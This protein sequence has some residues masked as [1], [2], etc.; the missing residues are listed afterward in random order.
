MSDVCEVLIPRRVFGQQR[1]KFLR[2]ESGRPTRAGDCQGSS[3]E[4]VS[5]KFL[6]VLFWSHYPPFLSDFFV[7]GFCP[8]S[9][10]AISRDFVPVGKA[11]C[12][13]FLCNVLRPLVI[14][15]Y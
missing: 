6:S 13:M 1:L 5:V 8:G 10:L 12:F 2:I 4:T 15:R 9:Y 14:F 7:L 11:S 3:S